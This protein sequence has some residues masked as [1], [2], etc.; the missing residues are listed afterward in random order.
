M[1]KNQFEYAEYSIYS[2]LIMIVCVVVGVIILAPMLPPWGQASASSEAIAAFYQEGNL[3]KRI[4]LCIMMFGVP[5]L[6]PV[7][8]LIEEII[9]RSMGMPILARVQYGTGLYGILFTILMTICWGAAAFR[10]ERAAET[11]QALHDLG[12]LLA[13]WVASA[14]ILQASCIAAAV[15]RDKSQDPVFPRWFGYFNI[16]AVVLALPACVINIF[17]TGPFA[18]DG[19]LGFWLPYIVLA[20][21]GGAVL[22]VCWQAIKKLQ[23]GAVATQGKSSLIMGGAL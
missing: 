5:F 7:F 19:L 13:T 10:P 2:A 16:W 22:F 6:V 12:W 23:L 3:S 21:W 17:H 18:Y 4:G 9:K 15:F 11:T 8:A 14:T 20:L 1:K